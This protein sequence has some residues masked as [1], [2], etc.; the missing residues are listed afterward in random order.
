MVTAVKEKTE[1]PYNWK[2]DKSPMILCHSCNRRCARYKGYGFA[3]KL[4][5][6]TITLYGSTVTLEEQCNVLRARIIKDVRNEQRRKNIRLSLVPIPAF[7]RQVRLGSHRLKYRGIIEDF[8]TVYDDCI[9][10]KDWLEANHNNVLP[11]QSITLMVDGKPVD[12]G[13]GIKATIKACKNLPPTVEPESEEIIELKEEKNMVKETPTSRK[14]KKLKEILDFA[15]E[16]GVTINP[17]GYGYFADSY[18]MFDRCPCDPM[19]LECPCI[20]APGEIEKDGHCLCHLF[21]KDPQTFKE[22]KLGG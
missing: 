5:G 21:W 12:T 18:L 15:Q 2:S 22:S 19:R 14:V 7:V 11:E 3:W 9:P 1:I 8:K 10:G 6:R 16:H 4:P 20:D 13:N 17:A